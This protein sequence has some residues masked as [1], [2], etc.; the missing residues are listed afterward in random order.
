MKRKRTG[1][2]TQERINKINKFVKWKEDKR[3]FK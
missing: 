1:R 3:K 2:D